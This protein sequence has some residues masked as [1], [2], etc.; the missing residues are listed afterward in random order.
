M[1][2]ATAR[3]CCGVFAFA[4]KTT[5]EGWFLFFE[6]RAIRCVNRG[7]NEEKVRKLHNTAF[8]GFQ[9]FFFRLFTIRIKCNRDTRSVFQSKC[10]EKTIIRNNL[11]TFA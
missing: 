3:R 6:R 5:R 11:I 1:S 7:K 9:D 4:K 8:E 2:G 10:I